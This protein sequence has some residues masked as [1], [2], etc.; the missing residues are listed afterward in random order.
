M[1]TDPG[2]LIVYFATALLSAAAVAALGLANKPK[3][4]PPPPRRRPRHSSPLAPKPPPDDG[5]ESMQ[6]SAEKA[7]FVRRAAKGSGK[8]YYRN[9][10]PPPLP[11][12]PLLRPGALFDCQIRGT[13][14]HSAE[15][16]AAIGLRLDAPVYF[17]THALIAP[18]PGNVHDP[19]AVAVYL[20]S[21]IVGYIPREDAPAFG[22]ELNAIAGPGAVQARVE[23]SGDPRTGGPW[24]IHLDV[25]RPLRFHR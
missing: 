4:K 12:Y 7:G 10:I 8:F 20:G 21:A 17:H 25:L 2:R 5:G 13:V 24:R 11:D 22:A 23:I 19:N 18:E 3:P 14:H 15:I 9:D 1:T 16:E 6:A